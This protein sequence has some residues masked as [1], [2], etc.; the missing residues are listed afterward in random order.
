[1][2]TRDQVH[3][4]RRR[5]KQ[6]CAKDR[7]NSRTTACCRDRPRRARNKRGNATA[8]A[9]AAP[10]HS[11]RVD[12]DAGRGRW[13]NLGRSLDLRHSKSWNRHI[14][15]PASDHMM[16]HLQQPALSSSSPLCKVGPCPGAA[17]GLMS[18][19]VKPAGNLDRPSCSSC[20]TD[21]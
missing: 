21:V 8:P 3:N 15:A 16:T 11:E 14:P 6:G 2:A 10:E 20:P 5:G 7:T 12:A 9:P 19:V 17:G 18:A 4:E 13:G 1:M